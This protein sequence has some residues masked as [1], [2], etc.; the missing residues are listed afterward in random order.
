MLICDDHKFIFLRNPKTGSRTI[1][2]WWQWCNQANNC[3]KQSL[4]CDRDDFN[5]KVIANLFGNAFFFKES[6]C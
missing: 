1:S 6:H 2:A 5:F 3:N 4:L